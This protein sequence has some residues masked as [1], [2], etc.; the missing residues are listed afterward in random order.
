MSWCRSNADLPNFARSWLFAVLGLPLSLL[1]L[2]RLVNNPPPRSAAK[3]PGTDSRVHAVPLKTHESF[4]NPSTLADHKVP[5]LVEAHPMEVMSP[6][7]YHQQHVAPQS[8]V[9]YS[10]RNSQSPVPSHA[11]VSPLVEAPFSTVTGQP[12]YYEARQSQHHAPDA[13]LASP[14]RKKGWM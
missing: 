3:E 8:E 11:S 14:Q 5:E 2:R 1:Y 13:A 10:A 12:L 7:A 9:D 6:V 4:S